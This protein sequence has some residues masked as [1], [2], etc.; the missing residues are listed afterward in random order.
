MGT[1]PVAPEASITLENFLQ[2]LLANQQ[3]LQQKI[4]ADADPENLK[5]LMSM[6]STVKTYSG[7]EVVFSP[8]LI[9]RDDNPVIRKG[10]INVLQGKFGVHKSRFAELFCSL[11][12]KN[13]ECKT[14]FMGFERFEP[15][16]F[17]VCYIDTERNIKEE[18]PAAVQSI[19]S[20]AGF[21]KTFDV[22]KLIATSMKK[23]PRKERLSAL[24]AY[25]AHVR[26][27][28]SD[29][30]FILLDVVTDCV[31][32]FN[33][34]GES[35]ELF[36]FLGN[37]ADELD[38]TFLLI[39]HENFGTE[40]AR[41]HTGSEAVNK[42]STVMQIGFEKDSR[43][44]ETDL[45][46]VKFLKLRSAK[47]PEPIYMKYSEEAKGLVSASQDDMQEMIYTTNEKVHWTQLIDLLESW[48]DVPRS[49]KEIVPKMVEQFKCSPNTAKKRLKEISECKLKLQN[50]SGI[51]CY[52]QITIQAGKPTMYELIPTDIYDR[53]NYDL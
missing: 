37:L 17:T 31:A 26:S 27:R 5:H 23:I 22:E 21:P 47:K 20:K 12:I 32:S 46:K 49:Q 44:C 24:K 19:R 42:A 36:D 39:I 33:K 16:K 28:T 10:T 50:V 51:D 25:L 11:L 48:L 7:Q 52:L 9:T 53:N 15:A 30:L 38:V 4:L 34:D 29:H 40:K 2:D 3:L 1:N 8:P 13:S 35:M 6:E 45:V 43:N 14:D 41:G 18:L